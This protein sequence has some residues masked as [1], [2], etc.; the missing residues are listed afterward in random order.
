MARSLSSAAV[1]WRGTL[2]AE[3]RRAL[4][5]AAAGWGWGA[6]VSL[7]LC[8][9]AGFCLDLTVTGMDVWLDDLGSAGVDFCLM[10]SR[11]LRLSSAASS[12][13]RSEADLSC[14]P[15]LTMRVLLGFLTN[16]RLRVV[17]R[18]TV[19]CVAELELADDDLA[20]FMFDLYIVSVNTSIMGLA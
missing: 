10:A 3:A 7:G 12:A 6:G 18:W 17:E 13:R 14:S 8:A 15:F 19:R 16:L 9:G 4:A 11:C 5:A 2:W 1:S 20:A